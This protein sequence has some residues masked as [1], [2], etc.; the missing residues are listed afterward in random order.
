MIS[1]RIGRWIVTSAGR[2]VVLPQLDG[3]GFPVH[4]LACLQTAEDTQVHKPNPAVFEGVLRTLEARGINRAQ[5][6]YVG[7]AYT[8]F[9]A[10]RRAGLEFFGIPRD[11]RNRRLLVDSGATLLAHLDE[12]APLIR[13]QGASGSSHS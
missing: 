1:C 8:D 10:A 5:V 9:D 6:A 11:P 4:M 7:D 2:S 12:L 13:G 3:M